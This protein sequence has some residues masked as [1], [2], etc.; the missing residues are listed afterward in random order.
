MV[1]G[2]YA[3]LKQDE[4]Y[5]HEPGCDFSLDSWPRIP[6]QILFPLGALRDPALEVTVE[7]VRRGHRV[8]CYGAVLSHMC[9]TVC[10]HV[11]CLQE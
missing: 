11:V 10:V 4:Q 8:P 5:G 6:F 1:R 3:W 9:I 2:G 7:G